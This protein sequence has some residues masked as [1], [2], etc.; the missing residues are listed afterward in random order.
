M[1]TG[2]IRK[3]LAKLLFAAATIVSA[4]RPALAADANTPDIKG[5]AHICVYTRDIQESLK[6]YTETLGFKLIH[7][8]E[9]QSGFKFVLVRKGSCIIELLEPKDVARSRQRSTGVIDHI[10]LE[11]A[12]INK[13]FEQLKAKG[14]SFHMP[15]TEDPNLFGG[16]KIAFFRGPS[17][18][19][20]ELFEYLRPVPGLNDTSATGA[21]AKK[22]S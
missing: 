9:L 6:F 16:V 7:Q 1:L 22:D 14:I 4:Q 12:D 19:I 18:E 11:V 15:V 20:F 10:A 5:L 21:P 8:T 17:G 13:A 3:N 2:R